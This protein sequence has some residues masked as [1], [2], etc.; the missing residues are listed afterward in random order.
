MSVALWVLGDVQVEL[1]D[2]AIS[3][4]VMR[5]EDSA[6]GSILDGHVDNGVFSIVLVDDDSGAMGQRVVLSLSRLES[7]HDLKDEVLLARE[8]VL[9]SDV[10]DS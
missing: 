9:D 1:A 8:V 6:V 10:L 3:G 4:E 2:A 5:A 7:T